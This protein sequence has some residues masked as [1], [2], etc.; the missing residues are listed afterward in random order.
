MREIRFGNSNFVIL[1]KYSFCRA[2]SLNLDRYD[3]VELFVEL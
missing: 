2:T 3:S 1:D